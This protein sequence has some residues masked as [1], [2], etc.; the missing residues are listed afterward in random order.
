MVGSLGPVV[1]GAKP[2]ARRVA[3]IHGVGLVVGA[4]LMAFALS[5]IG[6]SLTA[7]GLGFATNVLVTAALLA[8]FLQ[9]FGLPPVQSR[10]QVPE[11]WR[12]LIE[13]D[14]L[15]A[16]YGLLLGFGVLTAVVVS[17]FWVF[18]ALSLVVSPTTALAGWLVYALTRSAG[19]WAIARTLHADRIY[20]IGASLKQVLVV[21][22]TGTAFTAAVAHLTWFGT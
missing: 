10:W 17:A 18:V 15:A 3:M 5:V 16:V 14:V 21:A 4:I 12:R 22:A 8:A 6:A 2:A 9:V 11:R 20:V 13:I 7:V 1:D 19:F